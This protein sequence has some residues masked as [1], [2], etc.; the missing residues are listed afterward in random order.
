MPDPFITHFHQ[1]GPPCVIAMTG[2]GV[3]A[4]H[5]LLS[6]PGASRTVLEAVVPYAPPALDQWLGKAPD[7]YCSEATALMMAAVA[8]RRARH[9]AV[10]Q[11]QDPDAALGIGCTASLVSDRPKRGPHRVHVAVHSSRATAAW[12]LELEKGARER[13]GEDAVVGQLVLLGLGWGAQFEKAVLPE[14][15]LRAGETVVRHEAHG[16]PLM[17]ELAQGQRNLVWSK[18]N[19][20]SEQLA[21]PP[22]GILCGS[23]N[24]LHQA[25][26]HL[27]EFAAHKLGGPVAYEL[28]IR[29]ADKPPLDFLTISRRVAQFGEAPLALTTAATFNAKSRLLPNTTFVVGFDTAERIILP[30]YYGG[31]QEDLDRALGE[32]RQN[33]CRFLVMARAAEGKVRELADLHIPTEFANL[34]EGVPADE[35]REDLSSTELRKASESH[36]TGT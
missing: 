13:A 11:K 24:P 27:L 26:K 15:P 25:H 4:L 7:Q 33:N 22:V 6:V 16:A 35:F 23:F 3:S 10:A 5:A 20:L 2:G 31:G 30:K 1:H 28:S 17:V 8:H 19:V 34:F 14:L 18:G 9:L 29:N 32:L 12:S 36:A 21:S